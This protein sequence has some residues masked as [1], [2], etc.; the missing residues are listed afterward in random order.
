[1]D[2]VRSIDEFGYWKLEMNLE[3]CDNLLPSSSALA[4]ESCGG[5]GEA[6]GDETKKERGGAQGGEQRA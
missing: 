5:P 3:E 4:F 2:L 1:M 6:P